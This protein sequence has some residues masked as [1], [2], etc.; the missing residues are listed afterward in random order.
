M[1][2]SY[3]SYGTVNMIQSIFEWKCII[4]I[5]QHSK[6]IFFSNNFRLSPFVRLYCNSTFDFFNQLKKLGCTGLVVPSMSLLRL[7]S[8]GQSH[9]LEHC[10]DAIPYGMR[11]FLSKLHLC[12]VHFLIML[13]KP[14]SLQLCSEI[15]DLSGRVLLEVQ[16]KG[17][18]RRKTVGV[19]YIPINRLMDDQVYSILFAV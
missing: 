9:S 7:M 1:E 13:L 6:F 12:E 17:F 4:C 19:F 10:L 5:K 14:L 3:I 18:L 2:F 15:E 8:M 11:N 16:I